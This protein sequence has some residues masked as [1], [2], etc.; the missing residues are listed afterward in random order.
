M[1]TSN[2][3]KAALPPRCAKSRWLFGA[4]RLVSILVEAVAAS[5]VLSGAATAQSI[6]EKPKPYAAINPD[7]IGYFGPD[8]AASRDLKGP[9]IRIGLLVP[10]HGP[11]KAEG[12]TL[13]LAARLALQDQQGPGG[14]HLSLAIGDESGPWGRAGSEVARLVFDEQAAAIITSAEGTSAHL[15]EQIGNRIGVP[16][17]TLSSDSSTTE[18]NLPWI[19]RLAPD[20]RLQAETMARALYSERKYQKVVLVVERNHDGRLGA[21]ELERAAS[22]LSVIPP[23]RVELDPA[24][25]DLSGALTAIQSRGP[26]AVVLWT[27]PALADQLASALRQINRGLPLFLCEKAAGSGS[28]RGDGLWAVSRR[29]AGADA[30]KRFAVMFEGLA[31]QAPSL[32]AEATYD[33]VSLIA[34]AL[35]QAGPNRA[36]LRDQL[37]QVSDWTGI[38]GPVFFDGA[39]NN[40]AP[41]ALV[42]LDR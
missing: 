35:G 2:S 14:R 4:R 41:V 34:V 6:A 8:R 12:E 28:H 1:I 27:G 16:I 10:L 42:L 15:A 19:F 25:F 20:D 36:R 38:S 23:D 33:A 11:R 3:C 17:L 31:G 18:I 9:E 5:I 32:E 39:G 13:L 40:L 24:S 37:A 21:T 30:R 7:N 29:G 22:S 26:Q